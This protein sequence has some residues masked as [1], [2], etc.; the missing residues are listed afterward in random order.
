M[1]ILALVRKEGDMVYLSQLLNKPVYVG[2]REYA[3]VI[4]FG[5]VQDLSTANVSTI[6]IRKEGKKFTLPTDQV[7]FTEKRFFIETEDITLS[8][9]NDKDFY[10]AED[11][12]DKQVIDVTGRRLVRVNDVILK[13]NG[14]YKIVGIDIGFSGI[15]RRL[16]LGVV[17]NLR[18]ISIPWT[19]IEAFDYQ[20]G[21]V[22]LKLSQNSLNAFHPAEIADIL[23]DAG[24][25]ERLGVVELLDPRMAAAALGEADP[26]TQQ[27]ILESLPKDSLKKIVQK[28]SVADIVDI[29]KELNPFTSK[30]IF[31]NLEQDKIQN[32]RRLSVY[33]D[34]VAGGLMD[35]NFY[36]E[37]EDTTVAETIEFLR[38][39]RRRP[40]VVVVVD[41]EDT[42]KGIIAVRN[43]FN[44]EP[45]SSLK[46][47]AISA[48][49]VTSDAPFKEIL[50]T[51]SE[52]N[53]RLLPVVDENDKVIGA[54]SVDTVLE[55]VQ[56]GEEYE[57][58]I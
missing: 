27:S 9:Y 16:G 28:M 58:P 31:Q 40:E 37:K 10:L 57:E 25:K 17:F 46:D 14:V 52:Y 26:E 13:K 21:Q 56:R 30:E 54:I 45:D 36:R 44:L 2:Q 41:N 7:K 20:M 5:V 19:L 55:H 22:R 38:L 23:E 53:L 4:D 33:P 1:H 51:F 34:N 49:S 3:K 50:R 18:T 43:L 42:L 32:V 35:V 11:L 39:M 12:L 24:T 15:L 8:P 48:Q 29:L 6:L 47:V